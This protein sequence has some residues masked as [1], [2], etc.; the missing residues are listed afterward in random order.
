MNYILASIITINAK[1]LVEAQLKRSY[2]SL[3]RLYVAG[4]ML[5]LV[6]GSS[7]HGDTLKE[8]IDN[9]TGKKHKEEKK[10]KTDK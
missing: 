2:S 8:L 10:G 4:N 6:Q 7:G 3:L 5:W 1:W 9:V